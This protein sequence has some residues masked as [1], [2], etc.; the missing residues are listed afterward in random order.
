MTRRA[1]ILLAATLGALAPACG[2]I[3]L[4]MTETHAPPR[5]MTPHPREQ[6][7]LLGVPP[8]RP[9]TEVGVITFTASPGVF[10][11]ARE[12]ADDI[13]YVIWS[14]AAKRGCDAVV[15]AGKQG[16]CLVYSDGPAAPA[17]PLASASAAPRA[18]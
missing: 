2:G 15:L 11:P 5:P 16:A 10:A 14:Y 13:A 8:P 4:S 17:L 7:E 6:V 12:Y 9:C 18:P 3:S 1:L